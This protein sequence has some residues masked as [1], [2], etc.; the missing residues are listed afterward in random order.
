[1]RLARFAVAALWAAFL[2]PSAAWA[3]QDF[4]AFVASRSAASQPLGSGDKF[5]V[6]QGGITKYVQGNL[7]ADTTSA[8]TLTN[9]TINGNNN[10]LTILAAT[11]ISGVGPVANGFTGLTSY[12]SGGVVCATGSTTLA[13]SGALTANLP[14]IGG[15]AGVCPAVGSVT[16][17]TTKF[18]TNTGTNTS[19]HGVSWD[20]SGNLVD[21]ANVVFTN[22]AQ[23]WPAQQ[24]F[25]STIGSQNNQTTGSS[26]TLQLSDCGKTVYVTVSGSFTITTNATLPVGC[27]IAVEQGGAGQVSIANGSG[28]TKHN[29]HGFNNTFGQYAIIGLYVDTNSGGSA[30]DFIIT[31]DG[32]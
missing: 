18:V 22:V 21:N 5:P 6:I 24:T 23:I 3:T 11:Q 10:T 29:A 16:G 2:L 31:G 9:K 26:Y 1:M 32:V 25:G 13:S 30:A 15:G 19:G 14:V 7:V 8:Q 17:N 20:A 4:D 28:A 27:T 12:T